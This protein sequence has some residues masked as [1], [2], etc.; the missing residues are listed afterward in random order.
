MLDITAT[1]VVTAGIS[2][3]GAVLAPKSVPDVIR[4]HIRLRADQC[5]GLELRLS[6]VG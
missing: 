4:D 3:T 2:M 6:D 1:L 5:F